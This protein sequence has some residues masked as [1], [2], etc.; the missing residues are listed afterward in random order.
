MYASPPK[1]TSQATTTGLST[2]NQSTHSFSSTAHPHS[3]SPHLSTQ[4]ASH[5][6]L[7]PYSLPFFQH[8]PI[9]ALFQSFANPALI[10]SSKVQTIIAGIIS[11]QISQYAPFDPF[12]VDLFEKTAL[13]HNQRVYGHPSDPSFSDT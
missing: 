3:A 10:A 1:A 13:D 8:P 4:T 2:V 7:L 6:Y 9:K 11:H 5:Q 12:A